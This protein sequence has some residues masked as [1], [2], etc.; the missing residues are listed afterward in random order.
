[1]SRIKFGPECWAGGP[2]PINLPMAA[3]QKF[4][5]L[6]GAL[7]HVDSNGRFALTLTATASVLGWCNLGYSVG[8]SHVS[9]SV[10]SRVFTTSSTAGE[11]Q[12]MTILAGGE[13]FWMPAD[14]TFVEATHRGIDCDLI[15]VNDGTKQTADIGTSST[16]ILRIIDGTGTEVLV[17]VVA[18]I[19][20]VAQV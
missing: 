17:Q 12:L 19:L 16:N 2:Q 4:H 1:M 6:G 8:D 7:C 15:G 5:E 3:S 9:G 10:G 14:D 18:G 13:M 11:K 20:Q